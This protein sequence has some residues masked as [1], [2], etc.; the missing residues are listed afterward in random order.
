LY[1]PEELLVTATDDPRTWVQTLGI[2]VYDGYTCPGIW[3][4]YVWLEDGDYA[5]PTPQTS[6]EFALT[7]GTIAISQAFPDITLGALYQSVVSVVSHLC[8]TWLIFEV[9]PA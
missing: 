8:E 3:Q 1:P 2:S 9:D 4:L 7:T 6:T 5:A